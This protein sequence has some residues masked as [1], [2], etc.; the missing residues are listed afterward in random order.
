MRP[1]ARDSDSKRHNLEQQPQSD[2][3]WEGESKLQC[4]VHVSA[5][6]NGDLRRHRLL[7]SETANYQCISELVVP[8]TLLGV[9]RGKHALLLF[10]SKL[11]LEQLF[12]ASFIDAR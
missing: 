7:V 6:S 2:S 4:N 8:S 11:A 10:P 12:P 9:R 3:Q 5:D 1:L